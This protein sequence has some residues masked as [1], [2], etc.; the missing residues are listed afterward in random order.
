[1]CLHDR[2]SVAPRQLVGR[3]DGPGRVRRSDLVESAMGAAVPKAF[4]A[5]YE[6]NLGR[7]EDLETLEIGSEPRQLC[8]SIFSR[9]SCSGFDEF[10]KMTMSRQTMSSTLTT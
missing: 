3:S 7:C 10:T 8:A 9:R 6:L 1:M 5:V 4:D 2:K